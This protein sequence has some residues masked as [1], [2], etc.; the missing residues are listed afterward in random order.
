MSTDNIYYSILVIQKL[1]CNCSAY[2]YPHSLNNSPLCSSVV[3]EDLSSVP[4]RASH[5]SI[6][7]AKDLIS[8]GYL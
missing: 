5:T 4:K 7:R 6:K 8:N 2:K 1:K 3:P